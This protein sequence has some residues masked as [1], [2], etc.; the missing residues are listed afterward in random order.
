MYISKFIIKTIDKTNP[1][2]KLVCAWIMITKYINNKNFSI[3]II[4]LR[5]LKKAKCFLDN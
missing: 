5:G 3:T 2:G 1:T 4:F